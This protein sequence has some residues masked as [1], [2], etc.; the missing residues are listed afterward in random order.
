MAATP[1]AQVEAIKV[2]SNIAQEAHIGTTSTSISASTNTNTMPNNYIHN[3]SKTCVTYIWYW[4][5]GREKVV[6]SLQY[7]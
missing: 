7:C 6:H 1:I 5:L 2:E 4:W 3:H